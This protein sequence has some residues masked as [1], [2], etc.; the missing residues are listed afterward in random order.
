[1]PLSLPYGI[2]IIGNKEIIIFNFPHRNSFLL[3][4]RYHRNPIKRTRNP[5]IRRFITV[6]HHPMVFVYFADQV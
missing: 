4:P 3:S 6:I 2:V 1:M 5:D